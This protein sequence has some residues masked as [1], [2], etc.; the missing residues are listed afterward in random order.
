MEISRQ[1]D[2]ES[3]IRR[4][5][6]R[7]EISRFAVEWLYKLAFDAEKKN[8]S[9]KAIQ[10]SIVELLNRIKSSSQSLFGGLDDI[11][12]EDVEEALLIIYRKSVR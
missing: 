3:T 5:E 11:Q 10:F 1:A 2:M 6:K 7:L 4:F 12:L 9:D 8:V